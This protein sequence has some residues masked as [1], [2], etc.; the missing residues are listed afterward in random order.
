MNE[1][2]PTPSQPGVPHQPPHS[3]GP[4]QQG[5]PARPATAHPQQ[6]VNPA[7]LGLHRPPPT[8]VDD[9][10]ISLEDEEPIALEEMR[11]TPVAPAA[12]RLPAAGTTGAP[13]AASGHAV[14]GIA[15][16]SKIKFYAGGDKH[17]YTRFKREAHSSVIGATRVRSF[18]GRLSD[19]GLAYNDDKINE[20]LD[21]H[22][23]VEVKHVNCLIGP[24][25]GKVTGE[26]GLIVVIWY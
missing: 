11:R 24:L 16:G 13:P 14:A 23:E 25:E 20:W 10:P 1:P 6:R 21:N 4:A 8:L 19:D 12:P 5:Q 15:P 22:P 7:L 2:R 9:S 3:Q 26:Q 17:T 18:H